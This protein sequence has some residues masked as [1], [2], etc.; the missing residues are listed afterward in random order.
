MQEQGRWI[1]LKSGLKVFIKDGQSL[2]D[3]LVR[4]KTN[5][6]HLMKI[7]TNHNVYRAYNDE[8]EPK[9]VDKTGLYYDD[10]ED[11]VLDNYGDNLDIKKFD[12]NAKIYENEKSSWDYVHNNKYDTKKYEFLKNIKSRYYPIKNDKQLDTLNEILKDIE[13]KG[14]GYYDEETGTRN[15]TDMSF[16]AT[17]MIAKYELEKQGYDGVHWSNEEDEDPSQYQIW[18]KKI[19]K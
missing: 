18:N 17:Q 16:Y 12:K 19:L 11:Y 13:E 8:F 15:Y 10:D 5:T 6:N 4:Q 14:Y 7:N 2:V 1:T 9:N 3:A